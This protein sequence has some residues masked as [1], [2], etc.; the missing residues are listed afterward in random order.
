MQPSAAFY[1]LLLLSIAGVVNRMK[2]PAAPASAADIASMSTPAVPVAPSGPSM[3]VPV[4]FMGSLQRCPSYSPMFA[5][6]HASGTADVDASADEHGPMKRS[7][8]DTVTL[9]NHL[10]WC[11]IVGTGSVLLLRFTAVYCCCHG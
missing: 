9:I 5:D 7:R 1:R 6:V 3:K 2:A 10:L 8:V 11:T 4:R